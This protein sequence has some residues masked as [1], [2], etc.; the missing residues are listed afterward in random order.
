IE[1]MTAGQYVASGSGDSGG[2]MFVKGKLVGV[3]SGGGISK[4]PDGVELAIS[5][6][7]DLNS[8]ISKQFLSTV[9]KKSVAK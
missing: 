3:T 9:I 5:F 6:Y 7:V 1:G 4:T 8:S 2:P